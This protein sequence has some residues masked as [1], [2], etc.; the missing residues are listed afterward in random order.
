MAKQVLRHF[1]LEVVLLLAKLMCEFAFYHGTEAASKLVAAAAWTTHPTWRLLG[2][3]W[4]R[5]C[6]SMHWRL[7]R[8]RVGWHHAWLYCAYRCCLLGCLKIPRRML[9]L[10]SSFQDVS[11][12]RSKAASPLDTFWP[13]ITWR[14]WKAWISA[15]GCGRR[16][17]AY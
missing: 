3:G 16:W 15:K 8:G 6:C 4:L 13:C 2:W 10:A 17:L 12:R 5:L 7:K 11:A 1:K 14:T 9:K